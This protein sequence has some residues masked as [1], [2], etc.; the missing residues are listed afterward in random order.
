VTLP[1]PHTEHLTILRC[2]K[3]CLVRSWLD[4]GHGGHEAPS[5]MFDMGTELLA[6]TGNG[7]GVLLVP[8]RPDRLAVN[9]AHFEP[10]P[11]SGMTEF[12][13]LFYEASLHTLR[14]QLAFLVWPRE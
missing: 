9:P 5:A 14:A 2:A 3:H 1:G 13:A 12:E 6:L 8:G 7:H 11:T 10:W 4:D